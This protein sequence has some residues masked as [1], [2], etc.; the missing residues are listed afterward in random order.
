MK[1]VHKK[2]THQVYLKLVLIGFAEYLL[3]SIYSMTISLA[4][5]TAVSAVTILYLTMKS[6]NELS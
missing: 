5:F 6:T 3:H 2:I 1:I 4:H